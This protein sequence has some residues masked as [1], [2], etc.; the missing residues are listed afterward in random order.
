MGVS[1]QSEVLFTA[2]ISDLTLSAVSIPLHF[3]L[4]QIYMANFVPLY[5]N[6]V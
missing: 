5:Q 6:L 4:Q 3:N 1:V 2:S